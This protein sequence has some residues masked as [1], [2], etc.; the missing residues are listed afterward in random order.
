MDDAGRNMVSLNREEYTA[1]TPMQEALSRV[2]HA[3][4]VD[5]S[6]AVADFSPSEGGSQGSLN[7][8][9]AMKNGILNLNLSKRSER[10]CSP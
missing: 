1:E 8:L 10:L 9:Y 6:R 5:T 2:E 4:H 7:L 3:E